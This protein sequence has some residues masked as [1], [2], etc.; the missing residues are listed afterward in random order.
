VRKLTLLLLVLAI[1]VPAVTVSALAAGRTRNATLK[2]DYF[3]RGKLTISKGTTVVWK[4]NTKNRHT[5]TEYNGRWGT[6]NERKKATFRHKFKKKGKWT[7]Y[8]LVHP[9]EMRQKIVVK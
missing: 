3:T 1:A 4:W 7:V 8:C 6:T 2:D 9:V 5:V